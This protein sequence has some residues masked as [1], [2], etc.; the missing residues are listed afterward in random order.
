MNWDA[1]GAVAEA[2][3]AIGVICTLLFVAVQVRH[4]ARATE[5]NS[6]EM[7]ESR[8][9]YA[10]DSISRFSESLATSR[11]VASL[12][13]RGSAGELLDPDET[14]QFFW[15]FRNFVQ[16]HSTGFYVSDRGSSKQQSNIRI[17]SGMISRN[18]GLQEAWPAAAQAFRNADR[19]DFVNAVE[20]ALATVAKV[21][22]GRDNG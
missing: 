10:A 2:I 18:K 17:L 9:R 20:E 21:D 13:R 15:L 12:W 4:S 8:T 3:G 22:T 6:R 5:E 11:E 7:M 19:G 14:V 16:V 1:I